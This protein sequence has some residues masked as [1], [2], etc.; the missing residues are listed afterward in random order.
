MTPAPTTETRQY[1]GEQ[2]RGV[3]R[4]KRTIDVVFSDY[5]LDSF[6]TR[7]DQNGWDFGRFIKN[8]VILAGH[9]DRKFVVARG[10]PETISVRNQESRMTIQ[11]PDEGVNPDS[12]I[13]FDLYAD[14]FMRGLSVRFNPL[15]WEDTDETDGQGD[16]IRVRIF[17]RQVLEEVSLVAIPSN[18]NALSV[19]CAKLNADPELTR[20]R[21]QKYEE[22]FMRTAPVAVEE[23]SAPID[24]KA[25]YE[26]KQPANRASTKVLE[27]FFKARGEEAPADEVAAWNRMA[28]LVEEKPAEPTP[29][30]KTGAEPA[31]A[32]DG[33][34]TAPVLVGNTES[35]VNSEPVITPLKPEDP[36]PEPK[37]ETPE[38][39]PPPPTPPVPEAPEPARAAP[40]QIPV[41]DLLSYPERM[42]KALTDA[43]VAALRQGV[44]VKDVGTLI[45]GLQQ[46]VTTSFTHIRHGNPTESRGLTP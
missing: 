11:F 34:V 1:C 26:R 20:Q 42:T 12:D 21:I 4:Q 33:V 5:S 23:S 32:A 35:A 2:V 44:P 15:K 46:T 36:Q 25:Y 29:E 13:A 27:K 18:E 40:V 28:E 14:G 10:L 19:R 43:A 24:Y 16:R 39:T 17:R 3:D 22:A 45:D 38:E 31:L 8:P 9:D 6:N 37:I 41:R 30:P 7:F